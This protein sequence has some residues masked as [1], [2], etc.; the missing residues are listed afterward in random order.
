MLICSL[1]FSVISQIFVGKM[2]AIVGKINPLTYGPE[3]WG[4]TQSLSRRDYLPWFTTPIQFELSSI[5]CSALLVMPGWIYDPVRI[6]AIYA[7]VGFEPTTADARHPFSLPTAL[8]CKGTG[9]FRRL[10]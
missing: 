9:G 8:P 4:V 3:D 2:W 1:L 5:V 6:Q 7:G 10:L